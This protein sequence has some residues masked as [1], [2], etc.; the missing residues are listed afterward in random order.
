M[1]AARR[2]LQLSAA[3]RT[4]GSA[5]H[6][7]ASLKQPL[8]GQR[9]T[10]GTTLDEAETQKFGLSANLARDFTRVRSVGAQG[11]LEDEKAAE[12]KKKFQTV[13]KSLELRKSS[14]LKDVA[15]IMVMHDAVPAQF[16][17]LLFAESPHRFLFSST[18]CREPDCW[19]T[20]MVG[21]LSTEP[22]TQV[23]LPSSP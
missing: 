4:K 16:K 21:S 5:A 17:P 13:K 12:L 20:D 15:E 2:C 10:F 23:V 7:L 18:P 9:E 3:C 6:N 19:I 8:G 14:L 1:V 22:M 11:D